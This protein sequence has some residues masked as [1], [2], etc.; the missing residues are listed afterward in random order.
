MRTTAALTIAALA[1]LAWLICALA[2]EQRREAQPQVPAWH[3]QLQI[4]AP[5]RPEPPPP[6]LAP[7]ARG[8]MP[9]RNSEIS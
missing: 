7:K 9:S 3:A 4:C 1:W 6:P 2:V 5:I 8:I